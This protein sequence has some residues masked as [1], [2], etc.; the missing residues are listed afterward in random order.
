MSKY[1]YVADVIETREYIQSGIVNYSSLQEAEERI[2]SDIAMYG[3]VDEDS[4]LETIHT[5][6]YI[7]NIEVVNE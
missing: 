2:K 5:S 7:K 3:V 4:K 1:R 6:V